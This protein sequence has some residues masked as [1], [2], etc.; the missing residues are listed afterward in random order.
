MREP[1]RL[2]LALLGLALVAPPAAA[3]P[4]APAPAMVRLSLDDAIGRALAQNP[5]A[6]IAAAEIERAE[7]LVRQARAASLPTL[8]ANG[9]YTR[10]DGDRV[11]GDRVLTPAD[12]L[13]AN[14]ALAVPLVAP[15]AWARWSQAGDGV[16][17][18]RASSAEARR[19]LA[20]AV[21]RAYL[22]VLA[23]RRALEVTERARDTAEAHFQ[24]ARTRREGGVG[25]RIDVVRAEQEWLT[26]RAQTDSAANGLAR[27]REALAVLVGIDGPV[28]VADEPPVPAPSGLAAALDGATAR[29]DV[30]AARARVTA[31]DRAVRQSYADYAPLLTGLFQPFYQHPSTPTVPTT[32]WQAQLVLSLPLYDGGLR[33]AQ[34][35]E[36]ELLLTEARAA[37]D[38]ALRQAKSDVRAAFESVVR[39]DAALGSSRD[40]RARADEALKLAEEAYRAG[41][42]TNLEVVDSERRARDAAAAAVAT[43]DA[44]RQ[45]R[46]D[47]LIASG[48]LPGSSR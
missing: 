14:A 48:R 42:T 10:L 23:T 9:V 5:T 30:D 39:A 32:G 26:D 15:R 25:N 44:A 19:Q 37:Y 27:A 20:G 29:A 36:R 47:L 38:G 45:A 13:S 28:D 43:E 8:T 24:F 35:D 33:Y 41:A 31:T 40:A 3:E 16:Q 46:L 17:V 34:G 1:R 11:L 2:A 12:T 18:A 7:A 4:G 6:R 21:A 22:T